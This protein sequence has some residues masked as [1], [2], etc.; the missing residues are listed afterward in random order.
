ML[1]QEVSASDLDNSMEICIVIHAD[2]LHWDKGERSFI[3]KLKK[4]CKQ[5]DRWAF[6]KLVVR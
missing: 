6:E 2:N 1:S 3:W 4:C 5:A